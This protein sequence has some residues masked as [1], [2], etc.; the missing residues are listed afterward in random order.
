LRNQSFVRR[1]DQICGPGETH[2]RDGEKTA[3]LGFGEAA[4][5]FFPGA[6]F[7]DI[8]FF[9]ERWMMGN[10]NELTRAHRRTAIGLVLALL[11]SSVAAA[12]QEKPEYKK[13]LGP[14]DVRTVLYNWQDAKRDRAVPVK[15]YYPADLEAP[16]PLIVFS[17]GLGGSREGYEYLGRHWA[18]YGYISLHVQHIGSDDAVWRGQARPMQAIRQ[19]AIRPENAVNRVRDVSFVLDEMTELSR[20]GEPFQ[21][22][23]NLEKIGLAGHSF[24]AN[25]TLVAVGQVF[26]LPGGRTIGFSDP[27]I[28]A[29]VPMSAPAPRSRDDLDRVFGGILVPCLHMTGT[30]DDSPIGET[31]AA[32]RR[33]PFDHIAAPEQYLV[34]FIG[35][36]HMIF[37]G[38]PRNGVLGGGEKDALF[39]DLIRQ[40]T[41][42]FWDAYLRD[43][44]QAKAWLSGGG[45]T[46]LLGTD[47][48]LETKRTSVVDQPGGS[49]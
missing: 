28:K 17:H 26:I 19:A 14:F 46:A 22:R 25:T 43:D 16:A 2:A 34:I 3:F 29:A 4:A 48:T 38:R 30:L 40:A 41:T 24:G 6:D 8:I 39:Q 10:R 23:V 49:R 45:L 20:E 1:N 37:S 42:A 47:A 21:G 18:S 27:R 5:F 15:I 11:A 31:E 12:A 7:Q 9:Q 32:D 35:G 44:V 33:L 36:D 13:T